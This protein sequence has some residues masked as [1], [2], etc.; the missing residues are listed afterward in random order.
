MIFSSYAS[1]L[2][3]CAMVVRSNPGKG[4]FILFLAILMRHVK[5]IITNISLLIA[6]CIF[7][8]NLLPQY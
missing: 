7:G 6:Y 1:V 2:D 8:K 4:K 5:T 3:A